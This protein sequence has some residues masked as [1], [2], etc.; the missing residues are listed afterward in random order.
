MTK[1]VVDLQR[2]VCARFGCAPFEATERHK[3]GIARN[4]R[5]SILPINGMR[6]PPEGDST[7]WYIWAGDEPSTDPDFF[8]PLHVEHLGE[9]CPDALPYLKLPP[10]WRF[11]IAPGHEDVWFDEALVDSGQS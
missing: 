8:L 1:S 9:W 11:Q 10:G 6:V 7:G 4:V 3:V 2:N 5:E